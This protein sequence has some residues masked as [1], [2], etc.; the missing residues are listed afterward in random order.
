MFM[1]FVLQ[2]NQLKSA[3]WKAAQRNMQT[4]ERW[5]ALHVMEAELHDWKQVGIHL[6]CACMHSLPCSL[7]TC[8]IL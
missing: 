1:W 7:V 6:H 3:A 2:Y 8:H 4:E 5:A